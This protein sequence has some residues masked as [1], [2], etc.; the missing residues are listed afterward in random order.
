MISFKKFY[1]GVLNEGGAVG[2][3]VHPHELPGMTSGKKILELFEDIAARMSHQD[4]SWVPTVKIDGINASIRLNEMNEFV[5]DRGSSVRRG[6]ELDMKG[7]EVGDLSERFPP[8]KTTGEEHGFVKAGEN[9]LNIF[10]GSLPYIQD[11]IVKLELTKNTGPFGR[12]IN[13]EYVEKPPGEEGGINVIDYSSNFLA[14]HNIKKFEKIV[15]KTGRSW[16]RK[17]VDVSYDKKALDALAE[18]LRPIAKEKGFDVR[19]VY[20]VSIKPDQPVINLGPALD[21]NFI[22][23]Y[24]NDK[25][26]TRSLRGWLE[27]ATNPG[28]KKFK[29]LMTV[30]NA[31]TPNVLNENQTYDCINKAAYLTVLEQRYPLDHWV[32]RES[33]KDVVD[34]AIIY[35]AT[36]MLGNII[37]DAS[38]SELGEL[39]NHEGMVIIDDELTNGRELK[40]TGEFIVS[41]IGGR[42]AQKSV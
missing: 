12:L 10:N 6:G 5:I 26:E 33:W 39:R 7:V 23:R 35:H 21:T 30:D 18:K 41:G 42:I 9:V 27:S 38:T 17:A 36:R 22:V 34:G 40:I 29:C 20:P 8:H 11:E 19:T 28:R 16:S 2:H 13:M 1:S 4:D 31:V 14:M 24:T 25:S 32:P 3:M 37:L 15:S